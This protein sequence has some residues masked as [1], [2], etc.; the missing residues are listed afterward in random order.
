MSKTFALIIIILI[1]HTIAAQVPT[2]I[3]SIAKADNIIDARLISTTNKQRLELNERQIFNTD[4][5]NNTCIAIN[6]TLYPA[7]Y[8]QAL[9][10]KLILTKLNQANV[11]PKR[12]AKLKYNI[13]THNIL[14]VNI[15]TKDSLVSG[16]THIYHQAECTTKPKYM[17][18]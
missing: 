12:T 15:P 14:E 5:N 17:G 16:T 13:G 2:V 10:T 3:D 7:M 4:L 18:N 9:L 11:I 8:T 6:G 1:A